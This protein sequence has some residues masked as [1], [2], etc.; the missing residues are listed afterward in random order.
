MSNAP[1]VGERFPGGCE[2]QAPRSHR[3][4]GTARLDYVTCHRYTPDP[5]VKGAGR[6]VDDLRGVGPRTDEAAQRDASRGGCGARG[7]PLAALSGFNL[8]LNGAR[9]PASG[10]Q[11]PSAGGMAAGCRSRDGCRAA[12]AHYNRELRLASDSM[13][14]S[15]DQAVDYWNQVH[16]RLLG[17]TGSRV[18]QGRG[19]GPDS[20]ARGVPLRRDHPFNPA[21][22]VQ[23]QQVLVRR[24]VN[25]E[26]W[27]IVA[28]RGGL[29]VRLY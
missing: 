6:R 22:E 4:D 9:S 7:G 16:E 8:P 20:A 1:G 12:R 29:S 18:V 11:S 24:A 3:I 27:R 2:A 10:A 5:D 23:L 17:H 13:Q 14:H 15:A 21:G 26:R 28:R 25:S 19:R